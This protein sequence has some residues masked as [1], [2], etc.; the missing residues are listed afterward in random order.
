M[1]GG[2]TTNIIWTSMEL[3]TIT[4]VHPFLAG[5]TVSLIGMIIG[6]CFGRKPS[7]PILNIFE[8]ST[9]KRFFSKEFDRNIA[10]SLAPEAKNISS[11]LSQETDSHSGTYS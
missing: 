8:Q 10:R 3:E 4:A 7:Q 1:I 11:F 5:L 6:S 2:A 9:N